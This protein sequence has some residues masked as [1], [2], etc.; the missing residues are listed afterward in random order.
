MR[1]TPNLAFVEDLFPSFSRF[2]LFACLIGGV[3]VT[4]RLS[5]AADDGNEIP[6]H[7]IETVKTGD[8]QILSCRWYPSP[9]SKDDGKYV[10]PVIILHHWGGEGIQ[11][12][13]LATLLQQRGHAVIVPDL[14]GHGNSTTLSRPNEDIDMEMKVAD[15]GDFEVDGR[16]VPISVVMDFMVRRTWKP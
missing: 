10:V 12:D 4:S 16:P 14:R 15:D 3:V 1:R 6:K 11:F 7:S 8:G 2:V 13:A 9:K 5:F